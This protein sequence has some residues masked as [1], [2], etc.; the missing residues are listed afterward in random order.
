[1]PCQL[2]QLEQHEAAAVPFVG[3]WGF[4][5]G[6]A[7]FMDACEETRGRKDVNDDVEIKA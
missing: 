4:F 3:Y 5:P 1:M 2:S 6:V 7:K